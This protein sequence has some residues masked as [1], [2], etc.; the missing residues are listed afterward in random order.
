MYL[1]RGVSSS[2]DGGCGVGSEIW[3]VVRVVR[4][5]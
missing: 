4:L 5:E 1:I 3:V 2:M